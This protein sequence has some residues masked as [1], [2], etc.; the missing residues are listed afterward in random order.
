M[1]SLVHKSIDGR[2][3]EATVN[4]LD[5]GIGEH[6]EKRVLELAVNVVAAGIVQFGPPLYLSEKY[7]HGKKGH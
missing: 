4:L 5:P 2:M 6:D 1:V 3:V 7:G